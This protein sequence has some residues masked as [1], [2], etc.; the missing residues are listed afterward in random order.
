MSCRTC[1]GTNLSR[2]RCWYG[3]VLCGTCHLYMWNCQNCNKVM[4]TI[5]SPHDSK[6]LCDDVK[7]QKFYFHYWCDKLGEKY[8]NDVKRSRGQFLDG[9]YLHIKN[10]IASTKQNTFNL[11]EA[12][13]MRGLSDEIITVPDNVMEEF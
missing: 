13:G 9:I 8:F 4:N 2:C 12:T 7:C 11:R 3:D 6:G 1:S 10:F 5:K